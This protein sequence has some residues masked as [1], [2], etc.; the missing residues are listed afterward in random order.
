[1]GFLPVQM[2]LEEDS[3]LKKAVEW[4]SAKLVAW[5]IPHPL[6]Y[7]WLINCLRYFFLLR[8]HSEFSWM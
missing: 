4:E 3:F 5:L 8:M 6:P 7:T 1:M 2:V